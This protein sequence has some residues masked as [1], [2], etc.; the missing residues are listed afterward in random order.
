M[1]SPV[2]RWPSDKGHPPD[3]SC[4]DRGMH[5]VKNEPAQSF[6]LRAESTGSALGNSLSCYL[7]REAG[8]GGPGPPTAA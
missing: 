2:T 5:L 7:V 1:A 3:H 6:P 4:W 8:A